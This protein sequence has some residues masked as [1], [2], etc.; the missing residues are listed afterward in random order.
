VW[1]ALTLIMALDGCGSAPSPSPLVDSSPTSSTSSAGSAKQVAGETTA[2]AAGS[3][4][5]PARAEPPIGG[6]WLSELGFT[7]GPTGFSVPAETWVVISVD[8]PNTVALIIE[9][10]QGAA[11]LAYLRANLAGMG[12]RITAD[13][14][15]SLVFSNGTWAGA[16][17]MTSRQAGVT[18]RHG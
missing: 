5:G 7:H 1:L 16:F 3:V 15:D 12:F 11:M 18:L 17:T 6:V 2:S 13:R 8:Q 4:S 10:S 14:G 9:P